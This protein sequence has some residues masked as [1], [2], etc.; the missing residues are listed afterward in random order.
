[1]Q[2]RGESRFSRRIHLKHVQVRDTN[3]AEARMLE[4]RLRQI[5]LS[6]KKTVEAIELQK[7]VIQREERE[8]VVI[9]EDTAKRVR[10]AEDW[11]TTTSTENIVQNTL[12]SLRPDMHKIF[13]DLKRREVFLTDSIPTSSVET[14]RSKSTICNT[15]CQYDTARRS[16]KDFPCSPQKSYTQ[17]AFDVTT[18]SYD[19]TK[20]MTYNTATTKRLRQQESL[21]LDMEATSVRRR[22]QTTRDQTSHKI[23]AL[24][25]II[26]QMKQRSEENKPKDWFTNYGRPISKRK[27]LKVARPT[28]RGVMV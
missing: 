1:M 14:W 10:V 23:V 11:T 20:P 7:K 16:C 12:Q 6:A 25:K 9:N 5:Q 3:K 22:M 24:K 15:P 28:S 18:D 26:E 19:Y 21:I 27:L 17:L 8:R 13:K 4:N 2:T